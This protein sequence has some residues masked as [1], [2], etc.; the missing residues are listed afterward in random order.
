MNKNVKQLDLSAWHSLRDYRCVL[1]LCP[2]CF[3]LRPSCLFVYVSL[4]GRLSVIG[5]W[6]AYVRRALEC[7]KKVTHLAALFSAVC[8]PPSLFLSL[9]GAY[10]SDTFVSFTLS[11]KGLIN[12]QLFRDLLTVWPIWNWSTFLSV[13]IKAHFPW[14]ITIFHTL[15]FFILYNRFKRVA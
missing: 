1:R 8:F 2:V 13:C 5:H 14:Q 15:L 3:V 4:A 10:L 11:A 6:F 9:S 12:G 7:L